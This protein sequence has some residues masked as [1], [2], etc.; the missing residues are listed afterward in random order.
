MLFVAFFPQLVAGPIVRATTFLPQLESPARFDERAAADGLFLI[1]VGLIKKVVLADAVGVRL[2]DPVFDAP[3]S[4]NALEVVLGVYGALFQFYLDFS[5]Y[6]DIAIGSAALLGYTLPVNFDRPFLS[7]DLSEFWR[8]WHVTMTSWFRDY[9]FLSLGGTRGNR[10]FLFRNLM[11]TMLLT[12]LWHGAGWNYVIWGG[13]YGL[14]MFAASFRPR[15]SEEERASRGLAKRVLLRA[16]TFNYVALSMLFFRNG[17]LAEGN[18]GLEGSARMLAQLLQVDLPFGGLDPIGLS[19]L[20]VAAAIHF[21]PK[22]WVHE[23]ARTAWTTLPA[24]AQAAVLALVTGVLGAMAYQKT[25]FIYF[26]F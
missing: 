2:V 23:H 15:P 17:T 22:A 14:A 1:A 19:M 20:A 13:M 18:V 16:R 26:Q 3:G 6:S 12:G 9:V 25:P 7:Q 5:A 8:R 4:Y 24:P 21:T 10:L 11:V